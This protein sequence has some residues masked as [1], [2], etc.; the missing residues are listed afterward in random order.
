MFKA[1]TKHAIYYYVG[2]MI[3]IFGLLMVIKHYSGSKIPQSRDSAQ[4]IIPDRFMPKNQKND[5]NKNLILNKNN[6]TNW[7]SISLGGHS[8]AHNSTILASPYND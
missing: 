7:E 1:N 4:K 6:S 8:S 3:V 5:F 2:I